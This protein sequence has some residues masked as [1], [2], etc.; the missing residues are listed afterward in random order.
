MNAKIEADFKSSTPDAPGATGNVASE[1]VVYAL[2]SMGYE[3]GIDLEALSLVGD[4]ISGEVGRKN[5]SRA[6]SALA[7]KAKAKMAQ[8]AAA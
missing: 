8:A 4:W 6:G 2:H 5:S 7:R 1:D 3:T